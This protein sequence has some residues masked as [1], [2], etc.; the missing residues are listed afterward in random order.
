MDNLETEAKTTYEAARELVDDLARLGKS[1]LKYG[2]AVGESS[3]QTSART[4]DDAAKALRKLA[5]RI[6]SG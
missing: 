6:G 3:I 4:L 2:L 5:D 1:W